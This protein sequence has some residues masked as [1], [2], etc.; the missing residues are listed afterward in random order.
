MCGRK[1]KVP[2]GQKVRPT[3]DRVREA[4]FSML[5]NVIG[6]SDFI[7]LFAGSGVVGL[8]ALSRGARSVVCVEK[9]PRNIAVI[10]EN[11]AVLAAG[12]C[13]TAC[14]DVLRWLK[15]AG[16]GRQAD[17]VFADPPYVEGR[18]PDFAEVMELLAGRKVLRPGGFF[19][20]EMPDGSAVRELDG[21]ALLRD[22]TYGHTRLALYRLVGA[23]PGERE[24]KNGQI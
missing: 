13:E 2:A 9:D 24:Q 3:Q 14:C 6:G 5:V 21:W 7:D 17:V 20:A 10:R 15:S 12:A 23:P 19:V 16:A 11:A 22:R 4:L 8:E 1:I 18:W